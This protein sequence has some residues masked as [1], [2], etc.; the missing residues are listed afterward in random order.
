M[1]GRAHARGD[2]H[3]SW[4]VTRPGS[5]ETARA[6]PGAERTGRTRPMTAPF[7]GFPDRR[8][9]VAPSSLRFCSTASYTDH[10][11]PPIRLAMI[12]C[13]PM[14]C[15]WASSGSSVSSGFPPAVAIR[16]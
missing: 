13:S 11:A 4:A 15:D 6:R 1:T 9:L 12:T 10:A 16:S 8:M 2:V 7:S 3:S 5:R 14:S